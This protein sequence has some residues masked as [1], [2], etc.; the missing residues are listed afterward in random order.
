MFAGELRPTFLLTTP[1]KLLSHEGRPTCHGTVDIISGPERIETGWW[2]GQPASRDYFVGRNRHG[3]TMWLYRN[4]QVNQ[5]AGA[6]WYLQG[7]FA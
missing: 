1:R 6:D 2:D 5:A 3:E 4:H 7:Y